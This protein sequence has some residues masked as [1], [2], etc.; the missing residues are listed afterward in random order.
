MIWPNV[1]DMVDFLDV[2]TAKAERTI[3]EFVEADMADIV[4]LHRPMGPFTPTKHNDLSQGTIP[5]YLLLEAVGQEGVM[6]IA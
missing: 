3:R 5:I 6:I 1:M 2:S 4:A